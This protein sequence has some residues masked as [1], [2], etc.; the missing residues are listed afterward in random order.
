MSRSFKSCHGR[1]S[2]RLRENSTPPVIE[3]MRLFCNRWSCYYC[4][5]QKAELLR[6]R[7][8]SASFA[9]N[10]QWQMTL[11]LDSS[12]T[13]EN[14]C[15]FKTIKTAWGRFYQYLLRSHS[16]RLKY[17]WVLGIDES[18]RPHLHFL[19]NT[20]LPRKL[21]SGS[22]HIRGG[23]SVIH[24]GKVWKINNFAD[25]LACN[26]LSPGYPKKEHH[27]GS[28][29]A[30]SLR[31]PNIES[32]WQDAPSISSMNDIAR[33]HRVN[34]HSR[35]FDDHGNLIFCRAKRT[36]EFVRDA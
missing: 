34:L 32:A 36:P 1:Y 26:L 29:Q 15:P 5:P 24:T 18:G 25:Y 23:G 22:W 16:D 19:L 28:S 8:V 3:R 10:L 9:H 17:L 11:T 7:I 31:A 20:S 12:S 13:P 21:L 30:V 27:L 2:F 14:S 6:D 33:E 35:K 4:G